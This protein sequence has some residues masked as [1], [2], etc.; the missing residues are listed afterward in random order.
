[1]N[2]PCGSKKSYLSCCGLYIEH[3]DLPKTAEQLMRSRFCAYALNNIDYIYETMRGTPRQ[4]FSK[5]QVE[6]NNAHIKWQTLTILNVNDDTVEFEA[7]YINEVGQAR[8]MR[9]KSLFKQKN[10]RW[11]YI[12]VET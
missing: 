7:S 6:V 5:K 11:F 8:N 3:K 12:G 1:M 10:N 2:C 9:E 4:G